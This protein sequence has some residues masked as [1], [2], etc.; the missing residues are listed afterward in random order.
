VP[1]LTKVAEFPPPEK[2]PEKEVEELSWP[3][4]SVTFA[5]VPKDIEPAPATDPTV[6]LN[7]FRRKVAPASTVTAVESESALALPLENTP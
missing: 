5:G 7:P 6:S 2:T 3:A 4:V 1:T